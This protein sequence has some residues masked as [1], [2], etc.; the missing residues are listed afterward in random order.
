[1]KPMRPYLLRAM[2]DWALDNGCTP[3]VVVDAT[4]D[5]VEVPTAFVH[6]GRI[7]L[8]I[9]P[10]AVQG[11]HL[12][13][14]YL[15]FSARFSGQAMSVTIPVKAVL[16]VFARENGRGMFFEEEPVDPDHPDDTPPP[17]P[18]HRSSE[19]TQKPAK[20]GPALRVVK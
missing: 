2:Y 13:G 10:G 1:M 15:M 16:G 19:K 4:V 12:D 3:H 8:N 6:E 14:E 5:G 9:H 11:F 18:G 20:K 7:T 17:G